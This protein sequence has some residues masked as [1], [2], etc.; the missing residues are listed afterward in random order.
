ME[1][2]LGFWHNM[3][4]GSKGRLRWGI[5]YSYLT[6]VGWSGNA[7]NTTTGVA[8]VSQRP[9]AVDNMVWTSFRY[10]LP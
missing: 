5:Q 7:F 10:Y 1:G 6:K 9:K 8:G 3:Y 2:T 4:T